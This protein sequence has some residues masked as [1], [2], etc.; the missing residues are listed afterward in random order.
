M[1][2]NSQNRYKKYLHWTKESDNGLNENQTINLQV[3][4]KAHLTHPFFF[5]IMRFVL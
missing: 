3:M 2:P 5:L 1:T 4:Y